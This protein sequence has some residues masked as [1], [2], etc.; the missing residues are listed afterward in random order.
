M[1]VKLSRLVSSNPWW[2]NEDWEKSDPD[3]RS[4]DYNLERRN[5]YAPEG[6]LTVMRGIRRSGKTVYLK[7]MVNGILKT[8]VNRQ[9]VIYI[10]CDRFNRS[11]VRNIIMDIIVKRGGG[12]LLLDE[13]TNMAD[14]NLL[15][16][17]LM[18][19]GEFTVVATGSN[20]A[21]IG[22]M[23]ERLPGRGI[24]G[25][26]LYFNPLSFREFVRALVKLEHRIS[27]EFL[28][29][30]VR[31]LRDVD[32]RF[33]P[34]SPDVDPLFPYYEELERLFF[35]YILT[36][37][38][39]NAIQDYL[40]SGRV[41][42]E[43]YEMLLRMLLGTLSRN[44]KSEET[45]RR[46]MQ[47]IS[48]VGTGRTD[49]ITMAGNTGI[50][51]NTVRD[52]LELLERARITY[53]LFPWNLDKKAHAPKKQKKIVFQSPIIPT[54]IPLHLWGGGW[55]DVQEYVDKNMEYLVEDVIAAHLI[56]TEERPVLREQHSFAGYYYDQ[57]ECDFVFLKG[58]EFRGFESH[59]GKLKRAKYPFK[60]LYLTKDVMDEDAVPTSLFLYGLEK[61]PGS[62]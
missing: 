7:H 52:Y 34:F 56:W 61:G 60:T 39:P 43:T 57:H 42:E 37:G 48:A 2:K 54:S 24:E 38:F 28:L 50:H 40:K 29:K 58:G 5:I 44:K 26:E 6:K 49:Y 12:F 21:D 10:S 53:T 59:Y 27:D 51:H 17:E 41:S 13:V 30:A 20:P 23:T 18:E 55:E 45:A 25:N 4:I 22:N 15:L 62:L 46:V 31:I 11:E 32:T 3:L 47:E 14:W 33:S 1:A 19:Q 35:V 36:G 8:G 9:N 16:K